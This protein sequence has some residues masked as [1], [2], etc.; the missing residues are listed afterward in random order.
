MTVRDGNVSSPEKASMPRIQTTVNE[1]EKALENVCA[2]IFRTRSSRTADFRG[3]EHTRTLFLL[4]KSPVTGGNMD[5]YDIDAIDALHVACA[6]KSGSVLVTT[7]DALIKNIK[8]GQTNI[9]V[10]V[11]NPV[12]LVL[13][14]NNNEN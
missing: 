8:R 9:T 11:C 12:D 6:K 4:F 14:V 13:E 1:N 10:R 2:R 3:I 5:E 7:D